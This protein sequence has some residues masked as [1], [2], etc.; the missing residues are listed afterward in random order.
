M[1]V[2]IL[3]H[4]ERLSPRVALEVET[5]GQQGYDITIV[6]WY[7]NHEK[8]SVLEHEEKGFPVRW[9]F[10]SSPKGSKKIVFVL[11]RLYKKI[12]NLLGK[13]EF[14]II[15]C[16]HLYLLPAVIFGAKKNNA[17]V[18]YDAYG[19]YAISIAENYFPFLKSVMIRL[20]E[21]IENILVK[22]VDG[23]LT[24]SSVNEVFYKRYKKFCKNVEVLYNV[25][26]LST[27]IN[28]LEIAKLK[29]MYKGRYIICY[30]G[31]LEK[32][33]GLFRLVEILDLVKKQSRNILLLLI[34]EFCSLG[35]KEKFLERIKKRDL[36]SYV[37]II[38]W[39]PYNEMFQYVK[40]SHI[41]LAIYRQRE[42]F[43]V[44][45]KATGRKFFTYMHAGIPIVSRSFGEIG[46]VVEEERCGILVDTTSAQAIAKAIIFLFK[47]DGIAKEMGENGRRAIREKYNW[48]IE[49]QKLLKV[50]K[51]VLG[52]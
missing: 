31:G 28:E 39:I 37:K 19:R 1:K 14:D 17:K 13:E 41:G 52:Q 45:G 27:H 38:R 26:S 25:P 47:N 16:T 15:H 35:D 49:S 51:G 29:D 44:V 43:K 4:Y 23:I 33:R 40:I 46:K 18:I 3:N 50:Y 5:L 30:V 11:P 10:L 12:R 32:D 48:E 24:I 9:I 20:M 42:R 8:F 34:G 21:I 7:R 2:V 36:E 6:K 22:R